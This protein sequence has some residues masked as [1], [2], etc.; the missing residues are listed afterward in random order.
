MKATSDLWDYPNTGATNISKFSGLPGG[1][2]SFDSDFYT[3]GY[4]GFWW[5]STESSSDFAWSR[6]LDYSVSY[7]NPSA[8]RKTN[9]FSVRCLRD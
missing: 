9:G 1:H 4:R 6:F 8:D 3:I 7:V 2:R 5:S